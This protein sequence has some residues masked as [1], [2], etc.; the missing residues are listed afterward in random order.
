METLFKEEAK[1]QGMIGFDAFDNEVG[2]RANLFLG[3]PVEQVKK[4]VDFMED[5][6]NKH[7]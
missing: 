3:V 7:I 1:K 2:L 4:L 5:F 6:K